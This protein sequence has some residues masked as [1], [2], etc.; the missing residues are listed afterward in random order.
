MFRKVFR[1]F[2]LLLLFLIS[3][4]VLCFV[5]YLKNTQT[6][7]T[8]I[9][10]ASQE[11]PA[12]LQ[13][14][15]PRLEKFTWNYNGASYSIEETLY[16][17]AYDFYRRQPKAYRYYSEN[18]PANWKDEYF[19]MFL[20]PAKNDEIFSQIAADIRNEG[21]ARKLKDDQIAELTLAFVQAIPY[22]DER[23][24]LIL[25]APENSANTQSLPKYPYEILYEK[26]GVCS[27]K[28]F[29][30]YILLKNLGYGI[31]LFEFSEA[32]HMA[33]GIECPVQYSTASSGYC[34]GETT[35]VGHRIGI[36]PELDENRKAMPKKELTYFGENGNASSGTSL[37][38]PK[39]FEKT[40]GKS[41]ELIASTFQTQQDLAKTEKLLGS[42]RTQPGSLKSQ[43][44]ST[45]K[46]LKNLSDKL[47]RYKKDGQYEK[48]NSLVDD[49][50]DLVKS[51]KKL[52]DQ[53]NSKVNEYNRNVNYYNKLIKEFS[54]LE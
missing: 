46:E 52:V 20:E 18:L 50:N 1:I 3:V 2:I 27:D 8:G 7:E 48:Y 29:L 6:P 14:S 47:S 51:Y 21:L 26:R 31:S 45:E 23:A 33:I 15:G 30:A 38:N 49:Y 4:L 36:I 34:Y 40:E 43:I 12:V 11:E 25:T 9:R 35:N 5:V 54:I 42:L 41:Y 10:N 16:Q 19:R 22:D 44:D 24:K 13:L 17:S 37:E 39:I 32:N 53:Y 28:S